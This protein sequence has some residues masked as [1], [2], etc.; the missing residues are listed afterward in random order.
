MKE[1]EYYKK[2]LNTKKLV[3]SIAKYRDDT[4]VIVTKDLGKHLELLDPLTG[5]KVRVSATKHSLP[6][7]GQC[8]FV[9]SLLD[10]YLIT[11]KGLIISLRTARVMKWEPNH[12]KRK[13]ILNVLA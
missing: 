3:G 12:G 4:F 7:V 10:D 1:I 8:S 6:V 2:D 11:P 9:G 13:A 5:N